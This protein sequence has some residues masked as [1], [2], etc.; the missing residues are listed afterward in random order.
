MSSIMRKI[1]SMK[2]LSMEKYL[3]DKRVAARAARNR[4]LQESLLRDGTFER[5][6]AGLCGLRGL[7]MPESE[8]KELNFA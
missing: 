4:A 6:F 1:G 8:Q 2:T 5:A 3:E 7:N